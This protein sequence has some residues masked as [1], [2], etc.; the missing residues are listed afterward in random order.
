MAEMM[1]DKLRGRRAAREASLADRW[2][3]VVLAL[4]NGKTAKPDE[5]E[6]LLAESDK[7]IED[8]DAAV[9]LVQ[10]RRDAR[11]KYDLAQSAAVEAGQVHEALNECER[12][13]NAEIEAARQKYSRTRAPLLV[14]QQ[15][16]I[17]QQRDGAASE[18]FLRES[19]EASPEQT[20]K[21]TALREQLQAVEGRRSEAVQKARQ[22]EESAQEKTGHLEGK[23]GYT[24]PTAGALSRE[25]QAK[26][27]A[28]VKQLD[29][30]IAAAKADAAQAASELPALRDAIADLEQVPLIP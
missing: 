5:I 27:E 15:E 6:S 20:A 9:A 13:L 23:F 10:K 30:V 21:L 7:S 19:A 24:S 28:E 14:R 3:A 1:L 26:L 11:Q 22:A 18:R 29:G 4:A 8:L 25:W 16:L 17:R 2:K 12:L